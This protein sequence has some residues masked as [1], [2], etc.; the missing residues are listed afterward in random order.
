M[1]GVGQERQGRLH[2]GVGV[3]V[4]QHHT[5]ALGRDRTNG[6]TGM[7]EEQVA[8]YTQFKYGQKN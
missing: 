7:P 1:E 4:L 3:R 5:D 8:N 6:Q 2:V